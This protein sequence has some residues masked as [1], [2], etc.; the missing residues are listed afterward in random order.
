M[1]RK[2]HLVIGIYKIVRSIVKLPVFSPKI[3]NGCDPPL[4]LL[5]LMMHSL[6]SV[7][8]SPI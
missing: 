5:G 1:V 8:R 7:Y 4:C 6:S 2:E 3:L